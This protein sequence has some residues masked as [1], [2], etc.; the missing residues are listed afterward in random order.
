AEY[1]ESLVAQ[2]VSRLLGLASG[3]DVVRDRAFADQGFDS[4]LALELRNHLASTIGRSLPASIVFDHPT[5]RMLA[6]EL[7]RRIGQEPTSTPT[8]ALPPA[9]GAEPIA[10]IGMACRFPGHA[11]DLES[12]WNSLLGEAC[13]VDEITNER[14][15]IER[16]FDANVD[17]PDRMY[18]RH[19]A[20]ID[21]IDRFDAEF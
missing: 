14:W 3:D 1:L 2:E 19:M 4:V 18:V 16:Y 20:M 10:I 8:F 7:H 11:N 9:S 17:A 6:R 15:D 21:G 12:F 13:A 5:V